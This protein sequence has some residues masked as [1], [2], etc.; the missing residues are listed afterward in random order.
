MTTEDD[1]RE[2]VRN[3]KS[4]RQKWAV[5][6]REK[7]EQLVSI[8]AVTQE[9]I[10]NEIYS[11]LTWINYSSG[12]MADTSRRHRQGNVW[13]FGLT[14][15]DIDCYLK[16]QDRPDANGLVMWISIHEAERPLYFPFQ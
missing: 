3:I 15:S 10:L 8:L 6:A 7:N 11:R 12:P 13:I 4:R 5:S 1:A 14:I 2:I 9:E 16:F